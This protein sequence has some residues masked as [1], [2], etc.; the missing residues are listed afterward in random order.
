MQQSYSSPKWWQT[1]DCQVEH[2]LPALPRSRAEGATGRTRTGPGLLASG[3]CAGAELELVSGMRTKVTN[4][5]RVNLGPVGPPD[6]TWGRGRGTGWGT[7]WPAAAPA[8]PGLMGACAQAGAVSLEWGTGS[9]AD[10]TSTLVMGKGQSGPL[11][12]LAAGG[13]VIFKN[14]LLT[15]CPG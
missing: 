11:T 10:S 6:P 2:L 1:R 14:L 15:Q 9:A 4:G 7:G 13:N 3:G 8:P 12:V 5:G